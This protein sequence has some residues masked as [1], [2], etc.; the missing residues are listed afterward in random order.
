[1]EMRTVCRLIQRD[2]GPYSGYSIEI[3]SES[4]RR[5]YHIEVE[6]V[7]ATKSNSVPQQQYLF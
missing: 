2:T 1:M 3:T 6:N 4:A 7:V 5:D